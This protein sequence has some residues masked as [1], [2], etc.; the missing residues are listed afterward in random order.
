MKLTPLVYFKF[1]LILLLAFSCKKDPI[2]YVFEGK[3]TESV[4]GAG[5]AGVSIKIDQK[6]IKNG[7][8]SENFS[9][10]TNTSTSTSGDY[11]V[12]F[13]RE[14]VSEFRFKFEKDNYFPIEYISSS[15]NYTTD[16]PNAVSESMDPMAWVSFD[17]L[18]EFGEDT[19]HLKLITQTFREN[20]EGCSENTTYNIYGTIDSTITFPTT[21]GTYARFVYINVTTGFSQID[22]VFAIPFETIVY[23][24]VY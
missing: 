12:S 15:S 21:G 17:L 4:D 18:N 7:T 10:A 14:M 24:I 6:L 5:L 22:S 13:N 11:K 19:D 9:V 16:G 3:I 8:T 23:P 20:C 1:S 2:Q